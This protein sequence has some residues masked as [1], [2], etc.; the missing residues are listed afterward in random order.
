M[1]K[2]LIY[3]SIA[4]LTAIGCRPAKKVQGIE[5]AM[6]K[7]DSLKTP[8]VITETTD[9]FTE[10]KEIIK[11]LKANEIAFKTFSAKVKIDY[12]GD[13]IAD[14][15][16]ANIRMQKDSVI[17]ISLTGALGIEGFRLMVNKDSVKLMNKLEKKVQYRS[18]SYLQELTEIPVDFYGLQDLI[19]G[20]PV[21]IDSTIISYKKTDN[22]ILI[23][24]AGNVFKNLLSLSN[25]DLRI[26][27]SKLDDM[28]ALK[29]R[30]CDI[31][32]GD[33][34]LLDSI[35][36][37]TTR[38]ITVAEKSKLNIQ[39]IFK[40][41]EFNKQLTYPFTIPKNYTAR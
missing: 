23:L 1:K 3:I 22:E 36:F 20:N 12:E 38:K 26:I 16:T 41:Y 34:I 37:S 30:T 10:A 29:N 7:K 25:P 5:T 17:W 35:N 27:H 40:Q 8:G 13:A 14:Q 31:T 6:V 28:Q 11:Q 21:F 2:I 33:Y 15:A 19:I 32:Y 9:S 4:M 18:I 39:L 24:I